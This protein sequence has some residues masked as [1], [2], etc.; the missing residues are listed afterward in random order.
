[1]QQMQQMATVNVSNT[2]LQQQVQDAAEII[3]QSDNVL[4]K[5]QHEQAA[6]EINDNRI[7]LAN[8]FKNQGWFASESAALDITE[9]WHKTHETTKQTESGENLNISF[10]MDNIA[11]NAQKVRKPHSGISKDEENSYDE[12]DSTDHKNKAII[13]R[14][15]YGNKLKTHH[16]KHVDSETKNAMAESQQFKAMRYRQLLEKQNEF[17]SV[18][19]VK[20]PLTINTGAITTIGTITPSSGRKAQ[21]ISSGLASIVISLPEFDYSRWE[22]Y[23]FTTP[24]GKAVIHADSITRNNIMILENLAAAILLIIIMTLILRRTSNNRRK[25]SLTKII[26]IIGFIG[27]LAGI[28]PV[29]G[30]LLII[31]AAVSAVARRISRS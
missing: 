16:K 27:L 24:R 10:I 13:M 14:G 2:A 26:A 5:A 3:A 1:M 29:A 22:K 17:D 12:D 30:V 23:R 19:I 28:M 15:I 25:F 20:S 21:E 31:I 11:E 18:A 4:E 9:N 8:A 6:I 7:A